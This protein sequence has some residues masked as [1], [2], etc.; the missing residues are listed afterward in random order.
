MGAGVTLTVLQRGAVQQQLPRPRPIVP[1]IARRFTVWCGSSIA[2]AHRTIE[3]LA[4]ATYAL[5]PEG[6]WDQVELLLKA[7]EGGTWQRAFDSHPLALGD[8]ISK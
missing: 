3:D 2:P 1:H 7:G 6:L 8:P 5:I 4:V